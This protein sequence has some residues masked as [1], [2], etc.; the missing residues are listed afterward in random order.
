MSGSWSRSPFYLACDLA[1]IYF[2]SF[3]SA[4]STGQM[5]I[6]DALT[7]CYIGQPMRCDV[8][9]AQSRF[10]DVLSSCFS[11]VPHVELA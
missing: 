6:N 4:V 1:G 5:S 8:D 11:D 7:S 9:V 2:R 10:S 3:N